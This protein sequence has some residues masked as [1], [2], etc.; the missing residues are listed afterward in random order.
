MQVKPVDDNPAHAN[1][2]YP[3]VDQLLGEEVEPLTDASLKECMTKIVDS[4]RYI[5]ADEVEQILQNNPDDLEFPS[6]GVCAFSQSTG[7]PN[8]TQHDSLFVRP[9]KGRF[10]KL[11]DGIHSFFTRMKYF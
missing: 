10:I 6:A 11:I 9:N 5:S 3:M 2:V 4:G 7:N 1:I 8:Y